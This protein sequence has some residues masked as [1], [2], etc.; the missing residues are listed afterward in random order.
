MLETG[1][2]GGKCADLNALFVGLARAVGIPARDVYGMRVVPSQWGYKSLG[3]G[4]SD[5]TRAQ[6]C[7]AEFHTAALGWVPVDPADV[8]KVVL[9]EPPGNLAR[10]RRQGETRARQAVRRLGNELARLQLRPGSGAALR[11]GRKDRLPHVPAVRDRFRP[12]RQPDP[13]HFKYQISAK[14]I[15]A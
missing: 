3:A 12:Q 13:D 15:T 11:Q 9:E 1:N 5:I 10:R 2:L 4:S 7:R 6:H 14:E 8:R